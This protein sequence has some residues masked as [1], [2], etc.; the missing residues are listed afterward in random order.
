VQAQALQHVRKE[1]SGI[2]WK[3]VKRNQKKFFRKVLKY[4]RR[5]CSGAVVWRS[6]TACQ[7]IG[8]SHAGCRCRMADDRAGLELTRLKKP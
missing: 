7:S 5:S 4:P 2:V 8:A 6:L 3:T 1:F